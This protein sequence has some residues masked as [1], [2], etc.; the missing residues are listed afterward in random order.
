MASIGGPLHESTLTDAIEKFEAEGYRV[1]RLD[2]K[3]P[4]AIATKDGRLIA[5]EVVG[6][7]KSKRGRRLSKGWTIGGHTIAEKKRLYS[8]FDDVIVVC[9]RKVY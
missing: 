3:S 6:K 7:Y 5:I 9:Y 4:D 8:M 1:V 2:G